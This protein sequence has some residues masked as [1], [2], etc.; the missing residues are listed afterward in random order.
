MFNTSHNRSK[1]TLKIVECVWAENTTRKRN[2]SSIPRVCFFYA[3]SPELNPS[4]PLQRVHLTVIHDHDHD[5][6]TAWAPRPAA[7]S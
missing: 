3:I 2:Q 5:V 1:L 6:D 4:P 7:V